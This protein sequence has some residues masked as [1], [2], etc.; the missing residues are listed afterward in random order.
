MA[1]TRAARRHTRG[2]TRCAC[3]SDPPRDWA[4]W[5]ASTRSLH[6]PPL[7]AR[8]PQLRSARNPPLARGV[9][10]RPAR[11]AELGRVLE[12]SG[13]RV[14][15]QDPSGAHY[16]R[17]EIFFGAF[18]RVIELPWEADPER[19]TATY[20]DG[21]LEIRVKSLARARVEVPVEPEAHGAGSGER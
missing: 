6:V 2:S 12:V 8:G 13:R 5:W 16:Q 1:S 14:P 17:A 20:K 7:P 18:R 9:R 21:M 15:P 4:A 11:V 10:M 3:G 19:V